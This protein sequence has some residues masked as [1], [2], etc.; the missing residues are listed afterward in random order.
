[1]KGKGDIEM[2]KTEKSGKRT[3]ILAGISVICI[4]VGT[5]SWG[6]YK[7]VTEFKA[8]KCDF[9]PPSSFDAVVQKIDIENSQM[10]VIIKEGTAIQGGAEPQSVMLDCEKVDYK[11]YN[12]ETGDRIEFS[13]KEESLDDDSVEISNFTRKE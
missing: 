7:K 10:E 6:Y 3:L 12:T 11:L 4:V 8:S 1:M 9:V 5:L 13:C 2:K